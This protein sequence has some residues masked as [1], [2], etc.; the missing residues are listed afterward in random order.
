MFV[1]FMQGHEGPRVSPRIV[2]AMLL[3]FNA[4]GSAGAGAETVRFHFTGQVTAVDSALS[5]AFAPLQELT[6]QFAFDANLVD[7]EPANTQTGVYSP[8]SF[9][10]SLNGYMGHGADAS[11]LV[12]RELPIAHEYL[13]IAQ[14][15]LGQ[16]VA[17]FPLGLFMLD[18]MDFGRTALASDAIPLTPPLLSDY[19]TRSFTLQF[20]DVPQNQT[21]AINGELTSL[22][23]VPEPAAGALMLAGLTILAARRLVRISVA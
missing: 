2:M 13:V 15:S 5:G 17:G 21:H 11:I 8:V 6:G 16:P 7:S 22:T 20:K 4:L 14:G 12:T 18:L 10:F 19:D 9:S 3:A 23:L 1:N